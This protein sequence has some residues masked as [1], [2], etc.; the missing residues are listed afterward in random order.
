MSKRRR[1]SRRAARPIDKQIVTLNHVAGIQKETQLMIVQAG[2]RTLTGVRWNFNIIS[3]TNTANPD[4]WWAIVIVKDGEVAN[5]LDIGDQQQTYVPEQ[6]VLAFGSRVGINLSTAADLVQHIE[7]S[8]KSMRK[9]M[10][11]DKLFF[12]STTSVASGWILNGAVQF[13]MLF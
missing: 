6:N 4:F 10:E 7:G 13:F 5:P 3:N 12:I 11:G 9:M 1:I 2:A 8:T